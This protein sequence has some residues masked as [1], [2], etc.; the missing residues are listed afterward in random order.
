MRIS[1]KV[2]QQLAMGDPE[3]F[4]KLQ[5][6]EDIVEY[7]ATFYTLHEAIAASGDPDT[8]TL[9][10]AMATIK[11]SLRERYRALDSDYIANLYAQL[12]KFSDPEDE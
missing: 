2:L 3:E 8:V 4:D 12:F 7:E 10:E 6:I 5:M 9:W 11:T 1:D